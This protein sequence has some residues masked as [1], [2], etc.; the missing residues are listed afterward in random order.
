M[1]I[2]GGCLTVAESQQVMVNGLVHH[3]SIGAKPVI[4][5]VQWGQHGAADA[6]LFGDLADRGLFGSFTDFDVSLG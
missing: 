2:G 6:G 1:V 4:D 3:D 5:G